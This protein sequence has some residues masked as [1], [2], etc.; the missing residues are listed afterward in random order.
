MEP[1]VSLPP[2]DEIA[3]IRHEY[4]AR[5]RTIPVDFYGWHREEIQ[6]WQA[7]TARVCARLLRE[8]GAFAISNAAIADVGC[9]NGNWLLECLQWGA[10]TAN[11]HGIDLLPERIS[12]ARKRLAGAD[13]HCADARSLPWADASFDLV[14]QF[15]VFSSIL[16]ARVQADIASEMLR[17]VR[18][19][20]HILWYDCRYSNPSRA[21][22]RGLNRADVRRLFP[23]CSIRFAATTLAPPLARAVARR[24]WA[25]AKALENLRFTCT[26]L[27]AL[28]AKPG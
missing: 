11:L 25:A 10:V 2:L 14:M 12:Y 15:T 17:V 7:S 4:E 19:G 3:R 6:Y 8:S 24:S 13:L 28:I 26:H 18:P 23:S 5:A 9:G 20:G 16:D 1:K 21:A 22:V 27:A